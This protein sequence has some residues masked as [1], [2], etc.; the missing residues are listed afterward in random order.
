MLKLNN[1][2]SDLILIKIFIFLAPFAYGLFYEFTTYFA[3]VII[4]IILAIKIIQN[5]KIKFYINMST[6]SLVLISIGYLITSIYGIDKRRSNTRISKIYCTINIC[7]LN[8][9]IQ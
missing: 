5:K 6:V 1:E 9:A 8:D 3:Q 2:K 4:L 7:Y